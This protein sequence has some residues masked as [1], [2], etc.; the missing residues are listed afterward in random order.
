MKPRNRPLYS[1]HMAHVACMSLEREAR[2]ANL[3]G[4]TFLKL[5]IMSVP[6]AASLFKVLGGVH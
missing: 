1:P 5:R 3:G 2:G 4:R 6:L